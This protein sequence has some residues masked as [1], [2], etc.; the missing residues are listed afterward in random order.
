MPRI[1][2]ERQEPGINWFW[3][4]AAVILI[5]LALGTILYYLSGNAFRIQS[6]RSPGTIQLD[7]VI[8]DSGQPVQW[9][10]LDLE[11]YSISKG[12]SLYV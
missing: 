2:V 5:V 4:I 1:N 8:H 9:A 6:S 10:S 3:L 11:R 7:R 12:G